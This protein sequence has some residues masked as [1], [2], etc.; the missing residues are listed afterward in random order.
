MQKG[1]KKKTQITSPAR[2]WRRSTDK[3]KSKN[4]KT[5]QKKTRSKKHQGHKKKRSI[6]KNK[7][8]PKK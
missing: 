1:I 6:Q 7:K 8:E 4:K 3:N 5:K 2:S